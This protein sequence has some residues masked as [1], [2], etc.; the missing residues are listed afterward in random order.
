MCGDRTRLHRRLPALQNRNHRLGKSIWKFGR[1]QAV[2]FFIASIAFGY[3][4][5]FNG[6]LVMA[7]LEVESGLIT[8]PVG[9]SDAE[10]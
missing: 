1:Q 3:C 2:V 6:W 10:I 4:T 7:I 8:V 9:T 5:W